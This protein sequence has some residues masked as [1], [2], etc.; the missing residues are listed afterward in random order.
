[1][2]IPEKGNRPVIAVLD[3][4][5]LDAAA[6][7]ALW[8]RHSTAKEAARAFRRKLET[9]RKWLVDGVPAAERE[10]YADV[11]DARL[12]EIEREIAA[13]REARDRLRGGMDAMAGASGGGL[14]QP[15]RPAAHALGAEVSPPR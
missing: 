14:A 1:M 5:R 11:I 10:A 7:R 2:A 15:D 8:R 9:V 4:G 12:L 6:I 13:L 3:N